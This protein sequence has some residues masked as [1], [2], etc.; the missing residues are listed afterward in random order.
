MDFGFLRI[1]EGFLKAHPLESLELSSQAASVED[2]IVLGGNDSGAVFTFTEGVISRIDAEDDRD[3]VNVNTNLIQAQ[4]GS[5]FGSSGSPAVNHKT[6][7]VGIVCSGVNDSN[8]TFLLPINWPKYYFEYLIRGMD[9]PRGTILASFKYESLPECDRLGTSVEKTEKSRD[10]GLIQLLVVDII[11]PEGPAADKLREGDVV[12][13][14][15]GKRVNSH[16]SL[17]RYLDKHIGKGI[18]WTVDRCGKE[19]VTT[20]TTA[21]TDHFL[22]TQMVKFNG[23]GAHPV[24]LTQAYKNRCA[25]KGV[26]LSS[27]ELSARVGGEDILISSINGTDTPA[28]GELKEVLRDLRGKKPLRTASS[29]CAHLY[30]DGS[31][32][33]VQLK[34]LGTGRPLPIIL[35]LDSAFSEIAFGERDPS[36]IWSFTTVRLQDQLHTLSSSITQTNRHSTDAWFMQFEE[37]FV[38]IHVRRY[39]PLDFISD[40]KSASGTGLVLSFQEGLVVASRDLVRTAYSQICIQFPTLGVVPADVLELHPTFGFALLRYNASQIRCDVPDVIFSDAELAHGQSLLHLTLDEETFQVTE[41]TVDSL[42]T[43]STNPNRNTQ[44]R[45]SCPLKAL[46]VSPYVE[47]DIGILLMRG[48]PD[49]AA[50]QTCQDGLILEGR[51]V[52]REV[53]RMS[54]RGESSRHLDL[55]LE[56][57]TISTGVVEGVPQGTFC[58]VGPE[59]SLTI[60]IEYVNHVRQGNGKYFLRVE[61]TCGRSKSA[62]KTND[63]ILQIDQDG[64][65]ARATSGM[66]FEKD[67]IE[68]EVFREGKVFKETVATF[69]TKGTET[70]SFVQCFGL[71]CQTIPFNIRQLSNGIETDVWINAALPGSPAELRQIRR[72]QFIIRVNDRPVRTLRDLCREIIQVSN[73]ESVRIEGLTLNRAVTIGTLVKDQRHFQAEV[74]KKTS[75]RWERASLDQYQDLLGR[76]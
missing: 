42:S 27:P 45:R 53:R 20:I 4:L 15:D 54:R 12:W 32:I 73:G 69:P 71:I 57:I 6:E 74:Y 61:D 38:V 39:L 63:I 18:I 36:G 67:Q 26:A 58:T 17:Q 14:I 56:P 35:S 51:H 70:E 33:P 62:L 68:V 24:T 21:D 75:E 19:V 47:A 3:G 8:I 10:G 11:V 29:F 5:S 28:L 50:I 34:S 72:H 37:R 49:I 22:P 64:P 41:C 25:V 9:P 65:T 46:T 48:D 59:R 55:V 52:Q 13:S 40:E 44:E 76:L 1:D 60:R 30:I 23:F 66:L 43:R 7:V 2:R 16:D 31:S